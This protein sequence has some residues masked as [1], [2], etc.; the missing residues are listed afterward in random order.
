M[1]EQK[2]HVGIKALILNDKNELLLMKTAQEKLKRNI[3]HWDLPGG[4]IKDGDD[5]ET[6]LRK[7][8]EEETGIRHVKILDFFHAVISNIKVHREDYTYGLV[9][10]IYRCKINPKEKIILSDEHTE[11][12]WASIKEAK[13]LLVVKYPKD[14][15]EK[16]SEL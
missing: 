1:T 5:V 9:L 12:K 10:F 13:K 8:I 15:I 6:T 11:Y 4:R 3:V 14:F 2:F 16:L 7:E